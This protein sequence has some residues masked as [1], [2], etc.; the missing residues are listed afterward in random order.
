MLG[1]WAD[2]IEM[3]WTNQ[4]TWN[5]ATRKVDRESSYERIIIII[6]FF[7]LILRHT[8]LWVIPVSPHPGTLCQVIW[9]W[10]SASHVQKIL[11]K[12]LSKTCGFDLASTWGLQNKG[13]N[14]LDF[15]DHIWEWKKGIL[16]EYS[17]LYSAIKQQQPQ[18]RFNTERTGQADFV[19]MFL[20]M[21]C[22]TPASSSSAICASVFTLVM[23]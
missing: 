18:Q 7:D 20:M 17:P 22:V 11:Q 12:L 14:F 5:S 3:K 8:F 19:L 16:W 9:P 21:P 1:L 13:R 4:A 6:I 23:N 10:E 15:A 2:P